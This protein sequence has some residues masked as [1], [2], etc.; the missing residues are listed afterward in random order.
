MVCLKLQ[1]GHQGASHVASGKSGLLSRFE[2]FLL[3]H[4]RGIGPNIEL[5]WETQGSFPV[6]TGIL[7][8]L[9][10]FNRGVRPHLI[11]RHGT[12]LSSG[13]GKG[14]SGFLSCSVRELWLFLDKQQESQTF[15]RVV[16]GYSGF[17]SSPCR[18]IRPFLVLRGNLVSFW[19]EP[20]G[21]SQGSVDETDLSLRCRGKSGFLS[22]RSRGIGPHLEVR[23]DTSRVVARN[24]GFLSSG[25]GCLREPLELHKGS[26]APFRVLRGNSGLLSRCYS[27]KGLPVR[28]KLLVGKPTKS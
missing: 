12:M 24:S 19:Q 2:G 11:L 22:S 1:Q 14:V 7:G 4:S 18:G 20:W 28:H 25:H 16:R 5:R 8:F 17:H 6:V 15:L 3:S 10:S 27:V 21:S 26:Q 9:S 13:V 23:W